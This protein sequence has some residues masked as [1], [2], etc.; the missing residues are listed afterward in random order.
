MKIDVVDQ[1]IEIDQ[2]ID[3]LGVFYVHEQDI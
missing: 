1:I 2:N 3:Q